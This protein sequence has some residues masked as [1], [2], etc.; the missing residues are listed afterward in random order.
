MY[1]IKPK[2]RGGGRSMGFF[3]CFIL[4]E[5]DSPLHVCRAEEFQFVSL[6]SEAA[7]D[8]I[9]MTH[10]EAVLGLPA[11]CQPVPSAWDPARETGTQYTRV[12]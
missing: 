5:V 1:I 8:L 4:P 10:P 11:T 2:V 3:Y 12:Q 6:I 9:L 7:F